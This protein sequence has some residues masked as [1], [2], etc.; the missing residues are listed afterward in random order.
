MKALQY[1]VPLKAGTTLKLALFSD[2]HFDSPDCDKATL[3][4]HLDFCLKDGRYILIGGDLFDA[5]L[6]RDGKRAVNHLMEKGDNQLNI[7]INEIVEFLRPYK[8]NILFIGRGNHEE[9]ILKYSG[10]DI[11]ELTTQLLNAGSKHQIQYGNYANFLR[12]NFVNKSNRSLLH[13]DIFENHGAGGNSP[14]T[15]GMIDFNRIAKGTLTDLIWLGHKHNAIADYSDPIMYLDQNGEVK[16][17][18][19]QCIQ[20]PSYQRGR[21]VDDHN[22]N[23]AERFYSHQALPGFGSIELTPFWT[24]DKYQLNADVKIIVN[25]YAKIGEL[26]SYKLKVL[27]KQRE[28][29]LQ[30]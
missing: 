17:K 2:I 11:L 7:K 10:V 5:I 6:L 23:F 16:M 13:Y 4:K 1:N 12:F 9:S 30:K 3:K 27:Q 18:N 26:Q 28:N 14:V 20:T 22:V 29:N 24:D 19:R 21:T 8:D 25:P 15:K